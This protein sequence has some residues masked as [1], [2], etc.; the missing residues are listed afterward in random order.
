VVAGNRFGKD[1]DQRT[2]YVMMKKLSRIQPMDISKK[3]EEDFKPVDEGNQPSPE[4]GDDAQFR[5][6]ASIRKKQK[7]RKR[8]QRESHEFGYLDSPAVEVHLSHK[9]DNNDLTEQ[10]KSEQK[11]VADDKSDNTEEGKEK[12]VQGES[13]K[14]TESRENEKSSSNTNKREKKSEPGKL[15]D[16]LNGL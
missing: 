13:H 16:L 14:N 4:D 1:D 11:A 6:Y 3:L 8:K 9:N 10:E 7:Q 2:H 15:R 5:F 12:S